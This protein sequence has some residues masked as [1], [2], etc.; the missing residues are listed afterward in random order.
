MRVAWVTHRPFDDLGGAERADR[1]MIERR[2]Q[3]VKVTV[4][5]PGGVARDL[6]D[7]DR[8]VV[9][10]LYGFSPQELRILAELKPIIWAHDMQHAGH[11]IYDE[12]SI[13]IALN[14]TH[15]EWVK[16]R[17]RLHSVQV[18]LNPGWMDTNP[19]YP[20]TKFGKSALWAHRNIEHKGLGRAVEWADNMGLELEILTN[21]PHQQ[22]LEAMRISQ[23]FVLLSTIPDPGPF[24]VMEAHL[25]ECKLVLDNVGTWADRDELREVLNNADKHFWGLVCG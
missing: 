13:F 16:E 3:D 7:Y 8:V 5:R 25:C 2:P 20:L 11:W 21:R 6:G 18:E 12:A 10:G 17:N 4:V 14:P 9:A 22:V 1:T 24:A 23:Y 15:L 19:C